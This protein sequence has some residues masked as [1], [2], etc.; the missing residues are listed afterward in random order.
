VGRDGKSIGGT[1]ASSELD[2]KRKRKEGPGAWSQARCWQETN[3]HNGLLPYPK[4]DAGPERGE[5]SPL[6]L[7]QSG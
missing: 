4:K 1:S 6:R 3:K 2:L 7:L 5:R